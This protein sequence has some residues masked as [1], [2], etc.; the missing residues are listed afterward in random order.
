MIL[1]LILAL[2][3]G[4]MLT[5]L[6]RAA[7]DPDRGPLEFGDLTSKGIR[8][9][10]LLI[11]AD[12]TTSREHGKLIDAT[13]HVKMRYE[14]ESGDLLESFS[15]FAHYDDYKKTGEVYGDPRAVWKR[16]DPTQPEIVLVGKKILVGIEDESLSAFG[17]VVV[18]QSSSTLTAE[19]M[20]FSNPKKKLT[21]TGG[22]PVFEV[23]QTQHHT[24]ITSDE[25]VAWTDRRQVHF[26]HSVHGVVDLLQDPR[27]IK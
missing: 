10:P 16:K 2:S 13:G 3:L 15:K 21:A 19:E 27:T 9:G 7:E 1:R 11:S 17:H 5:G 18:T 24:R 6:C 20:H 23:R 22:P 14:M 25:I 12:E 26:N 8:H 4:L